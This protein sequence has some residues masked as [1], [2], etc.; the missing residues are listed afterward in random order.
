VN[1]P[2]DAL[3]TTLYG[4]LT[5]PD[6]LADVKANPQLFTRAFEEAVRWVAPIQL[7]PRVNRVP[8]TLQGITLP[9]GTRVSVIQA[10]GNRDTDAFIDPDAF[11]IH[12]S[13]TRHYSFGNGAHF[14]MGAHLSRMSIGEVLLPMLFERF[15][16]MA[17]EN[18]S[19]VPW[20]GYVFRGPTE[21]RVR[22]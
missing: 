10:S 1:E 3:L 15:P 5:N 17:L 19:A 12:R 7:S 11:N 9:A 6:Q 8:V 21:L 18:A 20:Y 22:L 16:D 14:C 4:L 13:E 2:R